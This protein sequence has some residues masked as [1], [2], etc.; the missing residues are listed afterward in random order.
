MRNIDADIDAIPLGK[1]VRRVVTEYDEDPSLHM[2]LLSDIFWS[3]HL[4][5]YRLGSFDEA[6]VFCLA[7][8]LIRH[9]ESRVWHR[10]NA[11]GYLDYLDV[12]V[13]NIRG[14]FGPSIQTSWVLD[15]HRS[16]WLRHHDLRDAV[17]RL[18]ECL[19]ASVA[20]FNVNTVASWF[21]GIMTNFMEWP[22]MLEGLTSRDVETQTSE[23]DR[24]CYSA[25]NGILSFDCGKAFGTIALLDKVPIGTRN[26]FLLTPAQF[27]AGGALRIGIP[28]KEIDP[29]VA[30]EVVLTEPEK[31]P[32]HE[33]DEMRTEGG[34]YL[35]GTSLTVATEIVLL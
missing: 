11:C 7:R 1:V 28:E 3:G 18:I 32:E 16:M 31:A 20:I 33:H 9:F 2:E 5:S 22:S 23:L 12:V 34:I 6:M 10:E 29:N 26:I 15:D 19:E 21:C 35:P 14:S 17:S 8:P 27:R 30:S 24:L 13:G 25:A 4:G